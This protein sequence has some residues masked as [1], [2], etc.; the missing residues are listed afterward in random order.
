[1][2]ECVVVGI[3]GFTTFSTFSFEVVDLIRNG[4]IG[5]A[6]LYVLLSVTLGI[7]AAAAGMVIV[8]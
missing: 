5:T 2:L 6:V 3:G 7:L 4:Q 1:M 8:K